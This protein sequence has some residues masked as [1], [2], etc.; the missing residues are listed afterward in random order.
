MNFI[1]FVTIFAY[2]METVELDGVRYVKA[3]VAAKKFKYTQDYIGQLCRGKKIDARLVGRTWFVNTDS[4]DDHRSNKYKNRKTDDA[5]IEH[6]SVQV[7]VEERD[8]DSVKFTPVEP[9]ITSKVAKSVVNKKPTIHRTAAGQRKL[10]IEY[11]KDEE[12]LLPTLTK[13]VEQPPRSVPVLPANA[14]TVRIQ[15]KRKRISFKPDELPEVSLSG[16]LKIEDYPDVEAPLA[17]G[18][19]TNS[20][21]MG[22]NNTENT[23]KNKDI[24]E[25][26]DNNILAVKETAG[27]RAKKIDLKKLDVSLQKE[28]PTPVVVPV[29]TT[30]Q[31]EVKS[32]IVAPK[33]LKKF[34]EIR[35]TD[36]SRPVSFH[37]QSVRA[38][39]T[40]VPSTVEVSLLTSMSPLLATIVALG[41][42]LLLFSASAQVVA[43]DLSSSST[44]VFQKANLLDVLLP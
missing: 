30:P 14:K 38:S 20:P 26:R 7:Q 8:E 33:K 44:L 4:I 34:P 43:H 3:S 19:E 25:E 13:R 12:S 17:S 28:E 6:S 23:H 42:V 35:Q 27:S 29:A 1:F 21:D 41:C 22:V 11:S 5:S 10:T 40:S 37:P 32:A 2:V 16:K 24:S 15:S 9:V 18:E 31:P 39:Q 36:T